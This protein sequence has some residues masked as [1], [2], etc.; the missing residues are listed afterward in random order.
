MFVRSHACLLV[1]AAHGRHTLPR[2]AES[3]GIKALHTVPR[4]SSN[5]RRAPGHPSPDSITTPFISLSNSESRSTNSPSQAKSKSAG[6][7]GS[8]CRARR[9]KERQAQSQAWAG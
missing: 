4:H 5:S 7:S 6:S 8:G 3:G 1:Q 2:A 9:G